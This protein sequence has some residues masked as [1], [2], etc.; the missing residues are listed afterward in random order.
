MRIQLILYLCIANIVLNAADIF[1]ST[2]ASEFAN[3]DI[4]CNPNEDCTVICDAEYACWGTHIYCPT[5][6]ACNIQCTADDPNYSK[7][8]YTAYISCPSNGQCDIVCSGEYDNQALSCEEM[9][10]DWPMTYPYSDTYSLTC[11][12][13]M[14]CFGLTIQAPD[15][16]ADFIYNC[17]NY[18][19]C[20]ATT[21]NCPTNGKC[22]IN[23]HGQN[24][25]LQ[26]IIVCAPDQECHIDCNGDQSCYQANIAWPNT[27]MLSTINCIGNNACFGAVETIPVS[28]TEQQIDNCCCPT[29]TPNAYM[30]S[31]CAEIGCQYD[32]LDGGTCWS[33]T[34]PAYFDCIQ[35]C[36]EPTQ[37]PTTSVPTTF[38]PTTFAPTTFA[39]TT[40]A[41]T[42]IP[43][44]VSPTMKIYDINITIQFEY[45]TSNL[46]PKQIDILLKNITS[47]IINNGMNKTDITE[48][49]SNN[50]QIRTELLNDTYDTSGMASIIATVGLCNEQEQND[51][52][53]Y[54][55]DNLETDFI[56]KLDDETD[57]I[58]IADSTTVY[59]Q[60]Y[61]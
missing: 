14:A 57:I 52:F 18:G 55:E 34:I 19:A 4:N 21:I 13:G 20:Q 44:T 11:N 45:D 42:P 22:H 43:T 47:F 50:Y 27:H 58:L 8:C 6:H 41:P 3:Q 31:R 9:T 33:S 53:V 35:Q 16:N 30:K 56:N 28:C 23:C 32:K 48:C 7:S 37:H 60:Y 38:A 24:A 10:V 54:F 2:V 40:F 36:V 15:D 39:P 25:C 26:S 51:L 46:N 17:D 1:N 12:G 29:C 59:V 5:N 61:G 49:N